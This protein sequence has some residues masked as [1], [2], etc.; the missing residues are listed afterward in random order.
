MLKFGLLDVIN[1][2]TSYIA[3]LQTKIVR[4]N[5][6]KVKESCGEKL[7][8]IRTPYTSFS[9][10]ISVGGSLQIRDGKIKAHLMAK[11]LKMIYWF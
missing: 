4:K 7:V 2:F 8:R 6:K 9:I 3:T 5:K 1:N 11:I 10:T